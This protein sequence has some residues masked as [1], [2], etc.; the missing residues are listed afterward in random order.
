MPSSQRPRIR[1]L[2]IVVA[3]DEEFSRIAQRLENPQIVHV[4]PR[5]FL[6]A[7]MSGLD[8][9]CV[10]SRIGKVA[11]ASTVTTLINRF[12]IDAVAFTGVAGGVVPHVHVGDLVVGEHLM[13]HD[14]DLKG[15]LQCNRF[16]IPL[17]G[18]AEMPCSPELLAIAVSSAQSVVAHSEYR[19]FMKGF[20]SHV[21]S[22]HVGIIASGDT[23]VCSS[24]EREGLVR[25][26]PDLL[27]VEMEGGAVSQVCLEY[28]IPFVVCR[29][30]S[31]A[32]DSDARMDFQA[33]LA[34]AASRGSDLFIAQLVDKLVKL[35]ESFP[36]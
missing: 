29:I 10:R 36:V 35:S 27:C 12:D 4:G 9:V 28:G 21:P 20:S 5:D 17:L 22:C 25:A 26:I 30:V 6:C 3:M 14:I 2:G 13:Q 19:A 24:E 16:D 15:V 34:S 23:F 18:M 7:Q 33:F 31:D 32:A 8:V 1:R 11:A